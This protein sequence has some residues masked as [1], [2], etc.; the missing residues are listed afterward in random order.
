M[1]LSRKHS[2]N[3]TPDGS[4]IINPWVCKGGLKRNGD[5]ERLNH[6]RIWMEASTI[7][8]EKLIALE[9]KAWVLD[10]NEVD[11][12]IETWWFIYTA[13]TELLKNR[14]MWAE[15]VKQFGNLYL[16]STLGQLTNN[17]GS[18]NQPCRLKRAVEKLS[19]IHLQVG[20]LLRF[21]YSRR[22]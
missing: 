9:S 1:G 19:P 18:S 17:V 13:G 7:M 22:M 20:T 15:D 8:N 4:H 14:D 16:Y 5:T 21:A 10:P 2:T 6:F 11:S 3:S 12:L